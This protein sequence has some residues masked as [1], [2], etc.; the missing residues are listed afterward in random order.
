MLFTK[1]TK[2]K[3][4]YLTTIVTRTI[5]KTSSFLHGTKLQ[6]DHELQS[7]MDL[8]R[9]EAWTGQRHA[10]EDALVLPRDCRLAVVRS[11]TQYAQHQLYGVSGL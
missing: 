3:I 5:V 8:Q 6:Y 2:K 1:K 9:V 10:A 7:Y 4:F 11:C